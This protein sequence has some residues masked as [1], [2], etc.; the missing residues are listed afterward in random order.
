M[1][2]RRPTRISCV[3]GQPQSNKDIFPD[4]QE[5]RKELVNQNTCATVI[6]TKAL[7]Q[8]NATIEA[9]ERKYRQIFFS[10]KMLM[11]LLD[12]TTKTETITN[13]IYSSQ[14]TN[15]DNNESCRLSILVHSAGTALP[16]LTKTRGRSKPKGVQTTQILNRCPLPPG[17][18]TAQSCLRF[19]T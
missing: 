1:I 19:L 9:Q 11:V 6:N 17:N 13:N 2:N 3:L 8:N 4:L 10:L 7:K 18:T 14:S 12:M 15:D 16:V 5:L